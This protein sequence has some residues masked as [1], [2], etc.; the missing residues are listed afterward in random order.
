VSRP[1][2]PLRGR[3]G[4]PLRGRV[5]LVLGAG[6]RAG[7]AAALHL[8]A[9]GAALLVAGPD[10]GAIVTTA[11]LIAAA[12][13][14]VRVVEEA[15]P[16]LPIADAYRLATDALEPP[17]DA[18][19]SAASFTTASAAKAAF[20]T[21]R[22]HLPAGATVVLLSDVPAGDERAAAERLAAAFTHQS[23]DAPLAGGPAAHA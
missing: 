7:Q 16:P 14:T 13:G 4:A 1:A 21:L 17:S 10:L 9:L 22:A 18:V 12:G 19:L 8:S 3:L 20:D 6:D 23:P 2:A 11:G 5:V 15:C